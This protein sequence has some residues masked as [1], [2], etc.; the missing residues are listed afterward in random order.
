MITRTLFL[1]S[2]VHLLGCQ[3]PSQKEAVVPKDK[4]I[5]VIHGGAGTITREKM[6]ATMDSIYRSVLQTSLRT[7]YDILEKGGTSCDAVI[8][9]ISLLED[10]PLFNAGVGAVFTSEMTTELDASI[11]RGSDLN[12]GAVAG[13][14][15]VK[16]PI[17]AA[18]LVME[19]S[20]H[21]M[22][23]GAGADAFAAEQGLE[24]VEPSYFSTQNRLE[25][26]QQ[27]Q[28]EH[29]TVGVVAL[30]TEGNLCAG[31]STGGM[32]N[33]KWGRIGDSPIIGA[34]TYAK[35]ATCG[36]SCTGYGEYFIRTATAYNVSALMEYKG[37]D[38]KTA[39]ELALK[40]TYDLG[41]LGGLIALDTAGNVAMPFSTEGMYRG[42]ITL[43]GAVKLL[44]YGDE[45]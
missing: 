44:I 32:T 35:N 26:L 31:T 42:Y 20:S 10:N 23:S 13:V 9:A 30:D 6:S 3:S 43:S 25:R 45:E 41:G 21:V 34:G 22:F 19:K 14:K 1:I 39:A 27:I 40:Q 5:L 38:I 4:V 18:F 11:M 15:T 16:N 28:K 24:I 8:A 2:I 37:L 29:G 12:A 17:K 33:K 7:G 36:V